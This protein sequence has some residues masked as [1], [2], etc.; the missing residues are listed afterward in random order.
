MTA[1]RVVAQRPIMLS[2]SGQQLELSFSYNQSLVERIKQYLWYAT[3]NR[4][5]RTWSVQLCA[6]N[7]TTL[8][9]MFHE[10][11]TDVSVDDLIDTGE[12]VPDLPPALLRPGS[13]RRP[14]LVVMG[15][16]DDRL[17]SRLRSIP[18]A[19]WERGAGGM[20]YKEMAA[21]ALMELV[22]RGVVAD[23]GGLLS[24]ADVTISFDARTGAYV[25]HG[26]PR[27]QRAFDQKFPGV[28]VFGVWKARGIDVAF[29]SPFSEEVYRGELAR[30]GDGLNPVGLHLP[31][32]PYQAQTVAVGIERSGLGIFDA[33]GLG[34]TASAIAIGHELVNNRKEIPRV[35][36]V[37]PGAV[38]TQ[39][40]LEITR[41][42][43]NEDVTVVK[44]DAKQRQ[45][46][47]VQAAEARW[48][49]VNY[50]VIHRDLKHLTELV[51]GCLL[52]ADE[53][54][55]LKS[56]TAKRTK[57]ARQLAVR[58]ARR[59]ALTGTPVENEPGE[60]YSVLSG[61]AIPGL[62][63]TP[64]DFFNRY[65]FPG[66]FGGYEGARNLHE[67]RSRS[68]VHYVR[69]TKSQVAAHLPPLRIQ[70]Y[71]IDPDPPYA[72][73]LLRAHREAREEIK[74]R[75]LERRG[76]TG[77][78]E[79]QDIATGAEMTAVGMLRLLCSSPRLVAES[80]SEAAE[81]LR[82]KGLVP[83]QDGPK[84]D[85]LR[86]MAIEAQAAGERLVVFS[87]SR[88]MVE[89]VSA[90]LVEDGVRHV[91]FTG[92]TKAEERDAAVAAFTTPPTTE[93]PGP[94][95]FLAT[96]AGAEGLNLGRC[97]ST[98]V[99]LDIPWT[100]A[101]LEQRANRIHRVD[102]AHEACLVVNMTLRG[103]LEQGILRMV[104]HKAD[105]ADA[106]FGERGGRRKTTG[107]GGRS[108]FEEA[109]AEWDP[110]A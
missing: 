107:R 6:H 17:Y 99:N 67:L 7:V 55:R 68:A 94:T 27:A 38:R 12:A 82:S 75:A 54:H 21:S 24:P 8:R 13:T 77:H 22:A 108:I 70:P 31:L 34:K 91:T 103:T 29:D 26:D 73:A 84:V 98:V 109:L 47:Y 85:E 83:D 49:V 35:V 106:I 60:W 32:Y 58:A 88:R 23:P 56:P 46:A 74:A 37:A 95:V 11:L 28:D 5:T 59:L 30:V 66:R 3:F 105:L 71:P 93:N 104:E 39:W 102:T 92:E 86:T 53:A 48:L 40:A 33:P 45:A 80:D 14:F 1:A 36:I 63:G 78:E 10:G 16:R 81:A 76:A 52:V 61:F 20:S 96:D 69:H 43:G 72:A 57:A 9:A 65:Q 51:G 15:A 2:R 62:F 64:T 100:P 25:V 87:F 97:C 44:G 4:T 42:T 110:A 90:R 101:R 18:G 50:D 19:V 41:F 79:E 89:L